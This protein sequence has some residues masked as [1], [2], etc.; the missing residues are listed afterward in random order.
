MDERSSSTTFDNI[1]TDTARYQ[2]AVDEKLGVEKR[3]YPY[4]SEC[5]D[6]IWFSGDVSIDYFQAKTN[7][8]AWRE[9]TPV[10][11]FQITPVKIVPRRHPELDAG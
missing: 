8:P 6:A 10:A 4:A 3:A 7:D 9:S 2:H 1:S 11:A 5:I